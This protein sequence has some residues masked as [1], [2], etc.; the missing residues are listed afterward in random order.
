MMTGAPAGRRRRSARCP[1]SGTVSDFAV[2]VGCSSEAFCPFEVAPTSP[3]IIR[4][5]FCSDGRDTFKPRTRS[6]RACS[7]ALD[8][9]TCSSHRDHKVCSCC[10][11]RPF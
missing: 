10:E 3:R 2:D 1:N 8:G 5:H 6:L 4:R 11:S 9:E 7:E